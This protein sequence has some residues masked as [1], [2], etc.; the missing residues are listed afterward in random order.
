[1]R[2][3]F[4]SEVTSDSFRLLPTGVYTIPAVG[5]VGEIEDSLRSKQVDYIVGRGAYQD[6]ARGR[7][8]GDKHGFL[9]ATR[10][11]L[12]HEAVRGARDRRAKQRSWSIS[13]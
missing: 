8:I 7:I 1:M 11:P 10:P 12:G 3:A 4:G 6:D 13:E 5:M 2:H 9:K